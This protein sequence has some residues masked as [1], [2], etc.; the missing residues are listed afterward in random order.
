MNKFS[1]HHVWRAGMLA[2]GAGAVLGM[3]AVML[4]A[5]LASSSPPTSLQP[6]V[7]AATFAPI[8]PYEAVSPTF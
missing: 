1:S 5:P 7:D 6:A 2:M 8:N 4:S 3:L